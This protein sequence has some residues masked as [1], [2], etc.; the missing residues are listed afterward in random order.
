MKRVFRRSFTQQAALPFEA[1]Q[2]A[3][4]VLQSARLHRYDCTADALSETALLERDFALWQGA[5]FCLAV[6]SGGQAL[7]LALRAVGVAHDA[8]VLTNAFTLA[9]VPGAIRAVGGVPML[10]E[11]TE[12]LVIDFDDL[13]QK[14][15]NTGARVL[16]LSHMRGHLADMDALTALAQ[17]LGLTVIEDCAHTMGATW[18]GQTSGNFGHVACFSTQTYKHLNSGEGGLLTSNDPETMARA[19]ILSGSYMNFDRHGA[20]PE[21]NYF[22]GAKFDC[23]NMS[24]RMDNLR[25]AVLRPQIGE[26][27]GAIAGWNA[28]HDL[29]AGLLAPLAP[30]VALPKAPPQAAR[31]G[32]SIQFRIPALAPQA[33][34]RLVTALGARGIEV[35]W[36]GHEMPQG[37]TSVHRHWRYVE[38]Q[39]LPQT[40]AIMRSLFDL[41]LPLSFTLDDCQ[42]LGEILVEELETSLEA[43]A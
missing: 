36:F 10:V 28:R 31:V 25:A 15:R 5:R 17:D 18:N 3:L 2:A 7:Q 6:T 32:S 33:A 12:D 39:D 21:P 4:S 16:L 8:P 9:P 40:D 11:V 34:E 13:A 37:F 30:R 41:R 1:L 42:L 24:A 38:P 14:A 20:A 35:K 22:Q 23:P 43:V 19:I 26:L 29:V 27:E